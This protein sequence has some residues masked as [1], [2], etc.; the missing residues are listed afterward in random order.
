[1]ELPAAESCFDELSSESESKFVDD[2][3]REVGL[4][5]CDHCQEIVHRSTCWRHKQ[6][7]IACDSDEEDISRIV[8][9]SETSI[10]ELP[11][12]QSPGTVHDFPDVEPHSDIDSPNLE[13]VQLSTIL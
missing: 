11:R 9:D 2:D 12:T 10:N 1:M 3:L 13:Q 5:F 6:L 7:R 4:E 8:L